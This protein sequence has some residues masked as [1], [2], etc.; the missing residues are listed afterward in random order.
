MLIN[1]APP[2]LRAALNR[3]EIWFPLKTGYR[4]EAR[5]HASL[6]AN[7]GSLKCSCKTLLD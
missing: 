1:I 6:Y 3:R 2:A 5:K 4:N 7:H